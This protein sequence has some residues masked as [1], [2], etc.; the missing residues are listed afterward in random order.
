MILGRDVHLHAACFDEISTAIDQLLI[1]EKD[2]RVVVFNA[3]AF[4]NLIPPEAIVYNLENVDV[5]VNGD[6]FPAHD[7]WDFSQRNAA[8]WRGGR[9]TITHVPA[10]YHVSME[11]FK[12]LPWSERDIDV[13]F[14][15]CMND[16]RH[17]VVDS[18][19]RYGFKIRT[20]SDIYGIERDKIVARAKV[21]INML[22]YENGTFPVLRTAHYA[23]NSIAVISE[24]ANEAPAWAYP[25]P[26]PY[27]QIV[28]SCRE[29]LASGE[30]R[31]ADTAAEALRRF[32]E[33]P[34]T[35]PSDKPR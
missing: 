30:E 17:R 21:T 6:A 20:L 2:P 27:H 10:G 35:L 15:G 26:V 11:R 19:A 4:P 8:R 5:Q 28:D 32:R 25:E 29:L 34:L 33:H 16:R 3:H 24:I 1:A 13:V 12:P 14:A 23:A 31:L 9:R 22:F 7:I 18:L